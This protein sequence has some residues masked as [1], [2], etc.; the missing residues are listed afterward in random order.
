MSKTRIGFALTG[1]FCTFKKVF[2]VLSALAE[3][4]YDITPILSY[5]VNRYDTRFFLRSQVAEALEAACGRPPLVTL[6]QVEPIG[7]KKLLDAYIIAPMTGATTVPCSSRPLPTTALARRRKIS[8]RFW[9][10]ATFILCPSVRTTL[11]ASRARWSRILIKSPK[12]WQARWP[13]RR[14]SRSCW[15]A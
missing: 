14:C 1:S 2:S 10:C 11:S 8:G 6:P 4:G 7:P 12:R 3:A 5:A 13:A 9:A 15:G